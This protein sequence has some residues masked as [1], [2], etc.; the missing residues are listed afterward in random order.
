M[1]GLPA[2]LGFRRGAGDGNR[3]RTISL[4]IRQIRA[5]DHPELGSRC[6]A[7]DRQRPCGTRV[8]GPPMA[9][10]LTALERPTGRSLTITTPL[11]G[12]LGD[13]GV[14]IAFMKQRPYV[15]DMCVWRLPGSLRGRLSRSAGGLLRRHSSTVDG[16]VDVQHPVTQL[17]SGWRGWGAADE[18]R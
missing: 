18:M 2:D 9:R 7:S 12:R 4:G 17:T 11:P 14:C 3:T 10:S 6:T 16:A 5:F 8:N 13:A 1:S 15:D